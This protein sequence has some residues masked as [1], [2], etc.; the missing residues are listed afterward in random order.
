MLPQN[1]LNP[2]YVLLLIGVRAETAALQFDWLTESLS[3]DLL[4]FCILRFASLSLLGRGTLK[5]IF[6]VDSN[7]MTKYF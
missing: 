5:L 7:R 4:S 1:T 3:M 2:E 6:E